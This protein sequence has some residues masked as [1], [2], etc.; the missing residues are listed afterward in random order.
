MKSTTTGVAALA[1]DHYVAMPRSVNLR[2][3]EHSATGR[4]VLAQ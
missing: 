3:Q 2:H 1:T 4:A